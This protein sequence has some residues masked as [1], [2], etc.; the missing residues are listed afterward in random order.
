MVVVGQNS[1]VCHHG[2]GDGNENFKNQL[3]KREFK[4][5]RWRRL[6]KRRLKSDFANYETLVS[7]IIPTR[8]QCFK[9]GFHMIAAIAEKKVQ[10]SQR[11]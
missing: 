4:T 2:D 7:A 3:V 6:Q 5:P 8:S 10:R 9:P 1:R 11:S